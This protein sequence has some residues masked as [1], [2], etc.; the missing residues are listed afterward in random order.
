A[1]DLVKIAE[2]LPESIPDNQM[3]EEEQV[4]FRAMAN[5]LQDETLRLLDTTATSSY[6]ERQSGY[7]ELEKTCTACHNLFRGQ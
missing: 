1:A 2:Q 4:T 5:Q 6:S 7:R 3:S